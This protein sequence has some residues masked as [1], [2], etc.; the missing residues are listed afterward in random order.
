MPDNTNIKEK[1]KSDVKQKKPKMY[2]VILHNDDYTTMEFVVEIL[3][4]VFNK[5]I[6]EATNIMLDVHNKGKGIVGV[7]PYDIAVTKTTQVEAIA[8]SREFPLRTSIEET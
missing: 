4:V 8:K 5:S 2:K 1:T 6:I 3:V 7:Y